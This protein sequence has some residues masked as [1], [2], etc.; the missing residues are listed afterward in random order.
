MPNTLY[1]SFCSVCPYLFSPPVYVIL[2][3][4]SLFLSLFHSISFCLSACFF[5]RKSRATFFLPTYCQQTHLH[6]RF[7][8]QQR[9]VR[10]SLFLFFFLLLLLP[11][12]PPQRIVHNNTYSKVLFWFIVQSCENLT[13]RRVFPERPLCLSTMTTWFFPVFFFFLLT[14]LSRMVHIG[15]FVLVSRRG[16][17]ASMCAIEWCFTICARRTES[18]RGLHFGGND[19]NEMCVCVRARKRPQ[20]TVSRLYLETASSTLPQL[21]SSRRRLVL[22]PAAPYHRHTHPTVTSIGRVWRRRCVYKTIKPFHTLSLSFTV[23]MSVCLSRL[24]ASH[25]ARRC[26][27]AV[28][29]NVVA[30]IGNFIGNFVVACH[31]T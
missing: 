31:R 29:V 7:L 24:S 9:S 19:L 10:L 3:S 22:L 25:S 28:S 18:A 30:I 26:P 1:Y 27:H 11:S 15:G 20:I 21:N 12:Y 4:L 17:G 14:R 2:V 5:L 23:C 16:W 8:S 6:N 13:P